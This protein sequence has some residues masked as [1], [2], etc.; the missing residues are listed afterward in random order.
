MFYSKDGS[1]FL[2]EGM[3]DG[4][5]KPAM[6]PTLN[7]SPN[8]TMYNRS[9]GGDHAQYRSKSLF[10]RIF[11]FWELEGRQN[12]MAQGK[13]PR[14]KHP[15]NPYRYYNSGQLDYRDHKVMRT[16]NI[17]MADNW[18][19]VTTEETNA[20]KERKEILGRNRRYFWKLQYHPMY[21]IH[22]HNVVSDS[23]YAKW[24]RINSQFWYIFNVRP[25]RRQLIMHASMI[26]VI[27]PLFCY[28]LGYH[29]WMN[30][31]T[32]QGQKYGPVVPKYGVKPEEY[33]WG[34][35][36]SPVNQI[37]K[38]QT[39][40]NNGSIFGFLLNFFFTSQ[41][42]DFGLM[43]YDSFKR[44]IMYGKGSTVP[45]KFPLKH[46]DWYKNAEAHWDTPET[47]HAGSGFDPNSDFWKEK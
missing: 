5:V 39:S 22:F 13:D 15:L 38:E 33:R 45:D 32:K 6:N 11:F 31:E 24:N 29:F 17:L 28:F 14:E 27:P 35:G 26:Y 19:P 46:P 10:R 42:D 30:P 16:P 40:L 21:D 2:V 41:N 23:Q 1:N 37:T 25:D 9:L 34:E 7:P 43:Q 44:N 36:L 12:I 8:N 18:K 4:N 47:Q 20:M 3:R